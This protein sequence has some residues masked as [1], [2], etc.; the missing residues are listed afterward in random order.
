MKLSR[1]DI[2]VS[3]SLV[4][5][6]IIFLQLTCDH[7]D[8][9]V[10]Q[11]TNS[12]PIGTIS[13]RYNKVKRKFVDRFIWGNVTSLAPVYLNDSILTGERSDALIKLKS[14]LEIELDPNSLVTLDIIENNIGLKLEKGIIR[15]K[16]ENKEGGPTFIETASGLRAN[17]RGSDVTLSENQGTSGIFVKSG[18]VK[19]D[20]QETVSS[21][22]ILKLGKDGKWSLQEVHIV[23]LKPNDGSLILAKGNQKVIN[24][25]WDTNKKID[26]YDFYLSKSPTMKNEKKTQVRSKQHKTT[27]SEGSWYWQVRSRKKPDSFFS[28]IQLINIQK[29]KP[30]DILSPADN[31]LIVSKPQDRIVFRW[32]QPKESSA[33]RFSLAS[34]KKFKKIVKEEV[35]IAPSIVVKGLKKGKYYWKV[36][37][38]FGKNAILQTKKSDQANEKD[39]NGKIKIKDKMKDNVKKH[40]FIVDDTYR[41]IEQPKR[42]KPS[43]KLVVPAGLNKNVRFSWAPVIDA[44]FYELTIHINREKNPTVKKKIKTNYYN[45]QIPWQTQEILWGVKAISHPKEEGLTQKSKKTIARLDVSFSIP[46][47]PGIISAYS[48]IIF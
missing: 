8:Q 16:S 35:L 17:I 10:I 1:S 12:K 20:G 2:I 39:L 34:D 38:E 43:S 33:V 23:N 15:A 42:L 28:N 37:T 4:S 22:K 41:V 47:A 27:L 24:F 9:R 36:Q 19:I 11:L 3:G 7:F 30:L 45:L 32:K 18:L 5:I 13:Y 29:F 40:V 46:P 44:K 26:G 31:T 48:K 21:G 14:G 25:Q 6:M